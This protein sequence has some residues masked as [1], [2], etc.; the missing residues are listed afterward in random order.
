MGFSL[1]FQRIKNGEE[2]VADRDGFYQFLTKKEL[3]LEGELLTDK[4]GKPLEFDGSFTDLY[5]TQEDELSAYLGHATLS[6][7]ECDFIF[8]MSVA[9]NWLIINP[10]GD[11]TFIITNNNHQPEDIPED[12]ENDF[13]FVQNSKELQLALSKGFSDFQ[14]YLKSVLKS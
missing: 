3:T 6:Y 9:A 7:T 10:Q 2:A 13:V 4:N 8:E 11:P 1:H 14:D 5:I 12:F